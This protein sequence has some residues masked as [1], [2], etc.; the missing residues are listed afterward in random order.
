MGELEQIIWDL[1]FDLNER[2]I[3]SVS[4]GSDREMIFHQIMTTFRR[5]ANVSK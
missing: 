1:L 4:N 2:K 5:F 3:I